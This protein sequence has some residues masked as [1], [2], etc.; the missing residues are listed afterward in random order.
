MMTV[1]RISK[2]TRLFACLI[3]LLLLSGCVPTKVVNSWHTDQTAFVP[4][5]VA[6]IAVLPDALIRQAVEADVAKV[7]TKKG[8]NA[9]ASSK[10]PG[11]AGGI[12]GHIDSDK[13]SEMLRKD[14]VDGVIVMFYTGGGRSDSYV[15]DDYYAEYIGTGYGYGW[16]VPYSV[17]V[18]TIK[19]GENIDQFTEIAYIES[20]YHDLRKEYAVWRIITETKDVEHADTALAVAGKIANQ[21]SKYGLN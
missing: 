21:M 7:L 13:A 5:K 4:N 2:L 16:A 9:V 6:V 17:D 19:R 8:T 11:M 20:S 3:M 12:R 10:I 18:Y 14:G 1:F 15:R